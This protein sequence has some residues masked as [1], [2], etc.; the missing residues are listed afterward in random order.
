MPPRRDG[1]PVIC[2]VT[3]ETERLERVALGEKEISESWLQRWLF[4]CPELLPID[5]IDPSFGPLVPIGCEVGTPAGPID[6]LYISSQGTLT[7]VE[8]KL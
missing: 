6:N 8:A 7:V 2:D 4:E 5:E 3:G 1:V